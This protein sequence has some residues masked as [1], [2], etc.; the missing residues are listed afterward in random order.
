MNCAAG[1][2][3][4]IAESWECV[5]KQPQRG[6]IRRSRIRHAAQFIAPYELSS[7]E[8]TTLSDLLG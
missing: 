1:L 2:K 6:N 5:L 7:G 3:A 4:V 8:A